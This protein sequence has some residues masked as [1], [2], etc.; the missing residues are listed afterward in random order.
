MRVTSSV[1]LLKITLGS[2]GLELKQFLKQIFTH[3]IDGTDMSISGL[4]KKLQGRGI[5]FLKNLFHV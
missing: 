1:L 5:F 3:F 4:D 2:K